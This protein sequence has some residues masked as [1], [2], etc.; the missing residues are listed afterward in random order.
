MSQ[1]FNY[2]VIDCIICYVFEFLF[3]SSVRIFQN[4][5]INNYSNAANINNINVRY[6]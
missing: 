5:T 2:N 1:L 6:F 4:S 3:Q